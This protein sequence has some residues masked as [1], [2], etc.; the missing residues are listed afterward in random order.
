M[1]QAKLERHIGLLALTLYGVGDILGAG[2]YGLVGK[3]AGFLGNGV[4]LAFLVGFTVAA[5]SGLTYAS[6]CSRFPKAAGSSYVVLKVFGS[7]FGAFV[8]GLTALFSG[9]TS[10]AAASRIF[11][12][13]F[14]GLAAWLPPEAGAVAF[15]TV[16]AAILWRGIRESIMANTILTLCEVGGLLIVIAVGIPYLGSVDYLDFTAVENA[17]GTLSAPILLSATVLVFYSFVGFE[18][19]INVGE[20]VKDPHRT[21]P[22]GLIFALL[23]ASVIYFLVAVVAVSVLPAGDLARSSQPLVEVVA[24]A[25]PWFPTKIFSV[26]SLLAVSNTALLNFLMGSRL[27]YGLARLRVLPKALDH[28]HPRRKTPTRAILLVYGIA[29]A[30]CVTGEVSTLARATSILLL[31]VFVTMN[32]SL[33]R[34]KIKGESERAAF[35]VPAFVPALGLVGCLVLLCFGKSADWLTAGVLL[36]V[37]LSLY[38]VARPNREAIARMVEED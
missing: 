32:L 35:D 3:A 8:V 16:I 13:Y 29:L 33:I 12:A 19:I 6:L 36:A 24:K 30:L 31:L 38:A 4:W 22:R 20:E 7:G 37:I 21:L 23:I 1:S 11:G 10:M 2:I 15:L 25:A 17:A 5:L 9:L 27:L 34:L 28:V 14:H 18:D 26:I